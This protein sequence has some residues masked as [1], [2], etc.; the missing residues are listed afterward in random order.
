MVGPSCVSQQRQKLLPVLAND[1]LNNN[2]CVYFYV[3]FQVKVFRNYRGSN[4]CWKKGYGFDKNEGPIS[5]TC[6]GVQESAFLPRKQ[7]RTAS[8]IEWQCR[9]YWPENGVRSA[10]LFGLLHKISRRPDRA[11]TKMIKYMERERDE[12]EGEEKYVYVG[13]ERE[14]R[15]T[16][17]K[18]KSCRRRSPLQSKQGRKRRRTSP[19]SC[20]PLGLCLPPRTNQMVFMK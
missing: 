10:S 17:A 4:S 1:L 15:K 20:S 19:A 8:N 16:K 3:T 18:R 14:S 5:F 13:D 12:N 6:M 11:L 9:R 2:I 7:E